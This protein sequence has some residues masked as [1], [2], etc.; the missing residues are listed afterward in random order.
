M[1]NAWGVREWVLRRDGRGHCTADGL[2]G[3]VQAGHAQVNDLER[4]GASLH[5][6]GPRGLREQAVLRLYV[7]VQYPPRMHVQ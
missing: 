2:V 7:P 1:G 5:H 6:G 4:G 3:A